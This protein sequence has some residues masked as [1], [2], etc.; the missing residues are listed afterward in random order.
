MK[1]KIKTTTYDL[2]QFL[3]SSLR[4]RGFASRV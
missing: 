2:I 1:S 4:L 3:V